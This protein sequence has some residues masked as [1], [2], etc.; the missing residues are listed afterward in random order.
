MAFLEK[1][2]IPYV[3]TEE[4]ML[5]EYGGVKE[6]KYSFSKVK[7]IKNLYFVYNYEINKN[8]DALFIWK[9]VNFFYK[10]KLFYFLEKEDDKIYI[11]GGNTFTL[12]ETSFFYKEI[13]LNK[14]DEIKEIDLLNRK[15]FG[16]SENEKSILFFLNF[17]E[18][19]KEF[20]INKLNGE[21]QNPKKIMFWVFTGNGIFKYWPLY[22]G[23]FLSG[24][25][26]MFT[27]TLVN[28]QNEDIIKEEE[29][30]KNSYHKKTLKIKKDIKKIK[31][32]IAKYTISK[33]VKIYPI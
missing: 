21:E 13:N 20:F 16:L 9:L 33:D 30:I 5:L 11:F 24:I 32:D 8:I 15:L 19:E 1:I 14:I 23:I 17:N 28:K 2:L 18:D 4:N 26:F 12:N 6:L 7:K 31:N 10:N 3:L 27:L 29:Q 22:I 25:I